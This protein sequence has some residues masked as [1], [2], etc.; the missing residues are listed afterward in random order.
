MGRSGMSF[1]K[2][3]EDK[4]ILKIPAYIEAKGDIFHYSANRI[5][6]GVNGCHVII[7]HVC[8]NVN[9]FG[10]GFARDVSIKYPIVKDNF[11]LLG[12]KA[13]LGYV[14]FVQVAKDTKY[15]H[16]LIF[17]NMIAQ[18]GTINK[19]NN[20]RP[21]NYLALAKSMDKVKDFAKELSKFTD[22][23]KVEI[24]APKFGSGLAGGQW[25]FITDLIEDIWSAKNG[26]N[27]YIYSK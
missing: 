17:A 11:H 6:E 12:N 8:N 7:P 13:Q 23:T 9:G 19:F 15:G 26:L 14:Q 5:R 24:H 25:I 22:G 2:M 4:M 3:G 18:N 16:T 1:R 10:S 20:P 27:V 21:L